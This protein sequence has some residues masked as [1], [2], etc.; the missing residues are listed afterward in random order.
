MSPADRAGQFRA[1]INELT[2]I[3]NRADE[4]KR[5]MVK[6]AHEINVETIVNAFPG[7]AIIRIRAVSEIKPNDYG[8]SAAEAI[9]MLSSNRMRPD[10]LIIDEAR[11]IVTAGVRLKD[12]PPAAKTK[13]K[14]PR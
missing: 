14:A 13:K 3:Q 11:M 10:V 2:P 8:R 12:L 6:L 4:L 5:E 7:A 9:L 1:L